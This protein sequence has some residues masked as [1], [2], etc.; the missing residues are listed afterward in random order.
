MSK[1]AAV[2]T[3]IACVLLGAGAA[4]GQ[5]AGAAVAEAAAINP[6]GIV[7][8]ASEAIPGLK[9]GFSA[10]LNILILLTVLSLAP[11]IVIMTSC[12]IRIIIVLGLIKQALGTQTLPPSQVITGL[13]LI[14][15]IFVMRP[16][17]ERIHEEA[18]LP[19]QRGEIANQVDMWERAKQ[20]IRDFMFDQIDA[21]G[22]WSGVYMMLNYKG[23]DTSRPETLTRQD[24]DTLSLSCAFVLSELKVAFLMG[25]KVYL[26]FL[27]IDIVIASILISM[28]MMMLPPV[29][30]SLPFKI[31][32]FILVDG[33]QLVVGSLLTSFVT[34]AG[35]AGPATG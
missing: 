5:S 9:G 32:L 22:N 2:W 27:V 33:W 15:T 1:A 13:A 25:F 16:T 3:A 26:P 34:P 28:S 11:A 31:L 8:S 19:Y 14:M 20:P 12:F 21:T 7:E 30:I 4:S 29:L 10:T 6:I 17:L 18:I 35:P 23:V 24:V